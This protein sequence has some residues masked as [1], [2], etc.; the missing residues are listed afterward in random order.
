MH[1]LVVSTLWTQQQWSCASKTTL[2]ASPISVIHKDVVGFFPFL[3]K[4]LQGQYFWSEDATLQWLLRP[5]QAQNRHIERNLYCGIE[6]RKDNVLSGNR[7]RNLALH[8]LASDASGLF[9][10]ACPA[11]WC[12]GWVVEWHRDLEAV[13]FT[14]FGVT[15]ASILCFNSPK[16]HTVSHGLEYSTILP[17]PA[18]MWLGL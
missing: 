9:L 3:N 1:I 12:S 8:F 11:S 10:P 6:D 15:L 16:Q 14:W 5:Q 17:V 4:W 7:T 13:A 18:Q 2:G